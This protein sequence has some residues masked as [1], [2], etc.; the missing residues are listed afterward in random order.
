MCK[1]KAGRESDPEPASTEREARDPYPMTEKCRQFDER[2]LSE[3]MSVV[4]QEI[5]HLV[6]MGSFI[7]LHH[8]ESWTHISGDGS[9]YEGRAEE[10]ANKSIWKME[11]IAAGDIGHF[12][13][14]AQ[15]L[16]ASM[17]GGAKKKRV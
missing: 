16:I 2:F 17:A 4:D 11:L 14:N 3:I 9:R 10:T 1:A 12:V 6:D 15:E 13:A 5:A 8:G 7:R